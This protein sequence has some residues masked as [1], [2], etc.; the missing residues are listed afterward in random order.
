MDISGKD[1][2][3]GPLPRVPALYDL[4]AVIFSGN[5]DIAESGILKDLSHLIG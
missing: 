4:L 5:D 1:Q 3:F 2:L